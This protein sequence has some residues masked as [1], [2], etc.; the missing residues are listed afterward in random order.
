MQFKIGDTVCKTKGS[1]WQGKIVG[2]YSTAL[3]PNGYAVESDT[4]TG[5][6]QIYPASALELAAAGA[7]SGRAEQ[8]IACL[9]AEVKSRDA[10]LLEMDAQCMLAGVALDLVVAEATQLRAEL[11]VMTQH[12]DNY[13]K[14]FEDAAEELATIKEQEPV[15]YIPVDRGTGDKWPPVYVKG[16]G[17]ICDYAPLYAAP[18]AKQVNAAKMPCGASVSNV[19]EAYEAG[20]AAKQVVMPERE[21]IAG[22]VREIERN[23]CTHEETHRGG[24]IWEICDSC[25]AK[26][27]DDRN[28]KPEFKW[29]EC[30]ENARTLLARLNAADQE[31][32]V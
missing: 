20:L 5:S 12:A 27:S 21:L 29:P 8:L 17:K 9:E 2:Q 3:T 31:G 7:I 14:M 28:P 16:S 15:A 13:S 25:G 19:Y 1:K 24:V 32:G 23:T 11:A 22:L 26:W 18:V 4:E 6:V 30:V 10:R